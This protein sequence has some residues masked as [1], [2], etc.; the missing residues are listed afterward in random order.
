MMRGVVQ[1]GGTGEN[2]LP[3]KQARVTLF[4]VASGWPAVAGEAQTDRSGSFT[5]DA[6]SSTS[7]GIF[8]ATANLGSG[9]VLMALL[10]PALPAAITINELTTVAAVYCA[11]KFI[12][13]R[14]LEGDPSGLRAAAAMST[15]LVDVVTG[16]SS[17][18][19]DETNVLRSTRALANVL[20]SCVRDPKAARDVLFDLATPPGGRRPSDTISAMHNIARHPATHVNGIY[21]QSKAVE[22]Y[23][24]A[25]AGA[26]DSWTL[27][28]E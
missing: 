1:S 8:Y 16:R 20:A 5:I 25:L 17:P 21:E 27:V 22:L 13:R 28:T 9:V 12:E 26:P 7:A 19:A 4:D 3:L 24:P 6:P 14:K 11:A 15:H 18:D 23:G 2:V 10:G